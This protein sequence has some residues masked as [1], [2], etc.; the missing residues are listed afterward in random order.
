MSKRLTAQSAN[1]VY[2]E[3]HNV[4]PLVWIGTPHPLSPSEFNPPDP[5]GG[6]LTHLREGGWAVGS[7]FGR[8]EKKPST[9]SRTQWVTATADPIRQR[10]PLNPM[11]IYK[12]SCNVNEPVTCDAGSVTIPITN[13]VSY[14][15]FTVCFHNIAIHNVHTYINFES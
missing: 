4:R 8:L 1:T 10:V 15:L 3:Y 13:L 14:S 5:K 12:Y 9:L 6:R 2:L 7:Q 11:S